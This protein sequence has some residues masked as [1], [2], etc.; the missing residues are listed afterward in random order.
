[1][2]ASL[3]LLNRDWLGGACANGR[4]G[5]ADRDAPAMPIRWVDE[6]DNADGSIERGYAGRSIFFEERQKSATT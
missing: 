6:W 4:S 3:L 2:V 5:V 1:M